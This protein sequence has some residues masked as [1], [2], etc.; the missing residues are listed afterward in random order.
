MIKFCCIRVR[1]ILKDHRETKECNIK[2]NHI[3]SENKK[4]KKV[5]LNLMN[6]YH[7]HENEPIEKNVF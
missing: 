4:Q 3:K 6:I 2:Q 7:W 5:F 1:N